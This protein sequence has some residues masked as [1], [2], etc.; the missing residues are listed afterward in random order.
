MIGHWVEGGRCRL[1]TR[2]YHSARQKN[3]CSQSKSDYS[4]LHGFFFLVCVASTLR[5]KR[6]KRKNTGEPN[7]TH[8][9]HRDNTRTLTSYAV[10]P[11]MQQLRALLQHRSPQSLVGR[12]P[13]QTDWLLLS[14]RYLQLLPAASV[15]YL[16]CIPCRCLY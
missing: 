8:R 7:N 9:T 1:R 11:S 4:A 12:R 16:V 5:D 10:S 13:L 2:Q 3:C 15:L 14:L 6:S